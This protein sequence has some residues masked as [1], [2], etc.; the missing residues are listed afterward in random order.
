MFWALYNSFD[1]NWKHSGSFSSDVKKL[2]PKAVVDKG[3]VYW[4]GWDGPSFIQP[5][6]ICTF[7][8]LQQMFFECDIPDAAKSDYHSLTQFNGGVG[9]TSYHN[10]GFS[11][12]I[13]V[14]QLKRD[15]QNK[16]DW[17]RMIKVSGIAIPYNPTI[18]VGKDIFSVMELRTGCG[19]S[20]DTER[21]DLIIA[22]L[23]FVHP[24]IEHILHHVW[25]ENVYVKSAIMHVES[26]YRV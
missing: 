15:G 2:G 25:E 10:V 3:V 26:L 23:K 8:M 4:V 6:Q 13:V 9:F 16:L 14:W 1:A 22:R 19:G 12:Q 7:D 17:E 11:K 18:F 24:R 20:N 5:S 21:T